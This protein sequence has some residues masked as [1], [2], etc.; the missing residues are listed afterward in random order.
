MKLMK[1]KRHHTILQNYALS[2]LVKC[3]ITLILG[4]P[5]ILYHE[6]SLN[7]VLRHAEEP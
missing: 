4:I 1:T 3:E 5:L 6:N 2:F 7:F